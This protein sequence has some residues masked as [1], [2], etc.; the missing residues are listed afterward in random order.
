VRFNT[1][2]LFIKVSGIT[3]EQDALFAI[4]LGAIAGVCEFGRT[5]RR[6]TP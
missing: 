1:E 3:S 4:G 6:F 5:A 2:G